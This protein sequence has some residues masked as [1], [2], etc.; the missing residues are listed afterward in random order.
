MN[1]PDSLLNAV[2]RRAQAEGRTVT[3]LVEQALRKLLA[4]E[5]AKP[6]LEPLPTWRGPTRMLVDIDDKDALDAALDAD[7]PR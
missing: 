5:N 1:L 2:R 7:G 3:S 6:A 4:E